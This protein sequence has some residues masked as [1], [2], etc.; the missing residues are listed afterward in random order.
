M[1]MKQNTRIEA[2]MDVGMKTLTAPM[3]SAMKL[4]TMRPMTPTPLRMRSKL[5]ESGYESGGLRASR[6]YAET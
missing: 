2:M 1:A 4:G 3:R 5:R 6:E